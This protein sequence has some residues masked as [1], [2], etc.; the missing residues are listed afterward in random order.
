MSVKDFNQSKPSVAWTLIVKADDKKDVP[1]LANA[2]S[3]ISGY[4]DAIY[5][6]LN[7]PKGVS[8]AP[9][10]RKLAE[11]Y[12]KEIYTYTWTGNFVKARNALFAKVPKK[13]QWIGWMDID[14]TI[15]N[16]EKIQPVLAIMPKDTNGVYILYDYDHDEYDN[17]TI[18]HWTCRI[19]RNNGTF[20]WKSSID[21]T[22]VSVHE[23]L[24]SKIQ[25][26]SVS[27]DEFKVIHHANRERRENSLIRN[28]ELLEGMY[29][30]QRQKPD[31]VDPRILFYLATHY[32]DAFQFDRTLDL[33]TEYLKVSGWPE[34]RSEADY[35][36]GRILSGRHNPNA[37][38]AF[39]SAIGENPNNPSA[40]V[41][42]AKLDY[43]AERYEQAA[44]WLEKAETI[45]RPITPMVRHDTKFELYTLQGSVYSNLGGKKLTR[46]LEC[47]TKALK[48][49]PY[50]PNAQANRDIVQ[51]LVDYR[52]DLKAATRLARKLEKEKETDKIL[53]FL[54]TLPQE[55]ADSVVV[56][57]FYQRYMP[58]KKWP[59]KSIAIFVGQSPLGIWGP[60]SMDEQGLGGSEESVI[61]LS[62]ELTALG[63]KIT[64]FGCPGEK[65]G[66]YNGVEWKQY[67]EMN[68][69]DTFDVLISWRAPHFYDY[70]FKARKKY[71]W[72]HDLIPAEEFTKERIKN[73]DRAIF[74]SQYHADRPEFDAI[75]KAKKFV[76]SNG[77]T[78]TD[79]EKNDGKFR[80]ELQRCIYMSANE[81]GLKVLYDIW[82]DVKKEVPEA[83][84]DIYYGWHSFDAINR[85]NPERM[86]WKAMMV[87]T[88]KSLK[89]VTERG[90]VGQAD[91][92][93]EIFRSGVFAYP[94][95]FP[96]VN[97]ITAQ[98]AMAGG[99]T[100]VTS[101]YAVLKDIIPLSY[102]VPMHDFEP[103]DIED[104]KQA[105]IHA[106]KHP[107][108]DKHR[109]TLMKWARKEF[110]WAKTAEGWNSEMS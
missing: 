66:D 54:K 50:D 93:E 37:K 101:D 65:A 106:L 52:D 9:E 58:P 56:Q 74:V 2:L 30:R 73:F 81:R 72:L 60:W 46:A 83:V 105:L 84:L 59:K 99:A 35:Y 47:A 88:A 107:T 36:I 77:I 75:P 91:L 95:M 20:A 48:L 104:Y 6:Q 67:W 96:E 44:V 11:Q 102:Q 17:V 3:S 80:R 4:V 49:R 15:D 78:P 24:I 38:I 42:L 82:P 45:E 12:T 22:E 51:Q 25:T 97:C 76:S 55:L 26:R 34:E 13:Y 108:D 33:L 103:E 53:P 87:E 31:G 79:F 43:A 63:W 86:A 14:D 16:P 39:L 7:T 85:D 32:F 98:K 64:V 71:L 28:I 29:N 94:C 92:T 27:N 61:R 69:Q 23:T 89:D 41:E 90:R 70:K 19:I 100:P 62:N 18:S 8:V 5:I 40:Y 57:D 10:F 68:A 110:D 21:D 1:L 109:K